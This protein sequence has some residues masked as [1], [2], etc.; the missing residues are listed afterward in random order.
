MRVLPILGVAAILVTGC[1]TEQKTAD[2]APAS[3][4]AQTAQ[5]KAY[6]IDWCV[7]S[8]EKLGSMGDPVVKNYQG[9]EVKFCCKYCVAEFDKT[10]AAFIARL[11]SA[12]AG[13]IHQP[14][15]E[16]HGG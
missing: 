6:P 4:S 11:D 13:L 5:A 9:R 16:G 7:V 3:G 8:G 1:G 2:N 14:T 10:P 12:A 15:S